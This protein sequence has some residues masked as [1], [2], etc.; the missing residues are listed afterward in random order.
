MENGGGNGECDGMPERLGI[1]AGDS[2]GL[3]ALRPT[4][5]KRDVGHRAKADLTPGVG[6]ALEVLKVGTRLIRIPVSRLFH[7]G[8]L[9]VLL[10]LC[11]VGR[12]VG[13]AS[14]ATGS[15]VRVLRREL[16]IPMETA[17]GGLHCWL[18]MPQLPGKHPLLLLTHGEDSDKGRRE[19]GPGALL[20]EAYWFV[21]RGWDVA[22]VL[23]R[24]FGPDSGQMPE[25]ALTQRLASEQ[26]FGYLQASNAQDLLVA[27][28]YLAKQPGV[29]VSRTV[30]AGGFTG[31]SAAMWMA[32]E[33]PGELKG[34]INFS[35]GWSTMPDWGL[36]GKVHVLPDVVVP[37][38]THLGQST[39]VP[40]LWLYP[41]SGSQFGLKS[42]EAAYQAFT[43]A[44]GSATFVDLPHKGDSEGFL[45]GENPDEWGPRVEQFLRGLG[46]PSTE[47]IPT[48]VGPDMKKL[49]AGVSESLRDGFLRYWQKGPAM[50]FAMSPAGGWGYSTGKATLELAR[51]E[52]LDNCES[53]DCKVVDTME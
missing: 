11:G 15:G 24:G 19:M 28:R 18:V 46:L 33:A 48:P 49:P 1:I 42:A 43:A 38:F 50:A 10:C 12:S 47:V 30:A 45:F 27:Y 7:V 36:K 21:R 53:K 39:H 35:G 14:P 44:G 17:G 4:S 51:H 2:G 52:A 40:M 41:R 34:V 29:D 23:R 9:A 5:Q 31:G 37:A 16:R 3:V 8:K 26:A 6:F 32:A 22:I 25:V 13:Q 20:P